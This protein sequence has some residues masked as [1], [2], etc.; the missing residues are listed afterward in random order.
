MTRF[1]SGSSLKV[2]A[3]VCMVVDH[4]TKMGMAGWPWMRTELF[5][6]GNTSV[7]PAFIGAC[8]IG[9]MA[10]PLFAFLCVEGFRHTRNVRKYMISM[11]VFAVL[12]VVPF[13]LLKGHAWYDLHEMNV[14]FTLLLGLCGIYCIRYVKGM[15][16]YA[17]VLLVL[18]VAYFFHC[19]YSAYGVALII[20]MYLLKKPE[21]QSIAIL[22]VLGRS[23]FTI[24]G[25]L[26]SVP[27]LLYNGKRGFIRGSICKYAFYAFYPLHILLLWLLLR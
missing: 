17:G 8:V 12:S 22:A 19:D 7:T 9:R 4:A 24:C 6:V 3:M 16:A 1:L 23:K 27:M 11:L 25:T 21:Y 2:I 14:L 18:A 5:T 13:N 26:A 15:K 20:V 10:F